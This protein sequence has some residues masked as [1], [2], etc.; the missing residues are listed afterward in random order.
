MSKHKDLLNKSL[1]RRNLLAKYIGKEYNEDII[2]EVEMVFILFHRQS[3][4]KKLSFLQ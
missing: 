4:F 2:N 1:I 3:I